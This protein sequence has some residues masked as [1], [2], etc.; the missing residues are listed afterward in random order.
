MLLWPYVCK[1]VENISHNNMLEIKTQKYFIA[2][3]CFSPQHTPLKR[4]PRNK[5]CRKM[6]S[7]KYWYEFHRLPS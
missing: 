6:C 2:E 4:F 7:R 1:T 5:M 3:P